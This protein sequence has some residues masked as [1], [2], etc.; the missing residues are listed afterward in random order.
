M[1]CGTELKLER[2]PFTVPI[3]EQ[4]VFQPNRDASGLTPHPSPPEEVGVRSLTGQCLHLGG[5]QEL[6]EFGV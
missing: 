1:D 4:S 5:G 6:E 2:S 3:L